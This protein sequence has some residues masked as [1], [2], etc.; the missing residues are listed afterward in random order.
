[1]PIFVGQESDERLLCSL[2]DKPKK[3]ERMKKILL[4][5]LTSILVAMCASAQVLVCGS[6][7]EDGQVNSP[8]IMSGTV[9]WNAA[10]QTL[11]LDN[12]VIDYSSNNPQ[13]GIS[14]I[15]VTRD[16]TIVVRGNCRLSTTGYVA[17]AADSYNS[18]NVTIK[19]NGTLTTSSSWIDIFLVAAHLNI[20]DITLSTVNGIG[21]N[22][23][24]T[25]VGLSFDNVQATIRGSISRIGDGITFKDCA[26]TYP[27]D[28]YIEKTDYGYSIYYGNHKTPDT[29]IISRMGG[30]QGDVNGDGEVNIA[31]VNAVVDVV[32][33]GAS[34][35]R[36]DVNNDNEINIADI[37]A[38]IDIILSG[39]QAQSITETITV[40]GVSFK[41]VKVN[42]GTYTM[43][44]RDNDT[45]AFNSEKPA[46]QV[47]VSSFYIGET[48][49]TQALWVA[50]MGS[51]NNPSHFTGDLNRPVDQ[52]SW[53]QC[54][55]FITKLNQMT[56]KQFRLPTEAEWE[57]AA[58]GGKM[59]KGY[60]YAG[61][62]DINEVAWWGYEK[63][64]T[65]VTYGTCPVASFKPN[66]LGL[67]DMTGNLFEWCQ[68]WYGGYSSEPQ[69][70][71]TG[72]ETGTDR[73]VRGGSWDFDAK[74]CR[75]SCRRSYSSN[76][77]YV[78]N[79]LR[80][81]M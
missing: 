51:N 59:S 81:A 78:C 17:I 32:L 37:N 77:N 55:E 67:Y 13:D 14:P 40:G 75:L 54:Q 71:P 1:M 60:K 19:G 38:L 2:N 49:V 36:A 46:H 69:T 25:G 57:Y 44:A 43:G 31:D 27:E 61:S 52:V 16:A 48:E 72:P 35:P 24:G 7:L 8:Y 30:I 22:A 73:I 29:I 41:M 4:L 3:Y 9:T 56:G 6:Y 10:S 62:N 23:E 42:G 53:N 21:N 45:E 63:G 11:T 68:D 74:F 66:E 5:L 33:G 58:R 34:N 76:G 70:N 39:A 20:Q 28:A 64:G 15:R 80:L 65:C 12:A 26:I 18:K 50:V 79:G 47:T